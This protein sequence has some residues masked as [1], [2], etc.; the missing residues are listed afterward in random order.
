MLLRHRSQKAELLKKVPMFSNLS[1]RHLNEIAK[2]ADQLS[3]KAGKVLAE[4][5]DLGWEFVFILEGKARV[6]KNGK[7]INRLSS[8]DFFGE[9]SLIDRGPRTATVVTETDMTLLIVNSKSF[10]HLLDTVTG[11]QKKILISLCQYLRRAEKATN[12]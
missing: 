2:Y 12:I 4:Q 9:I 11:L 10:D 7:V 6:E 1:N 5:G 8:G 3:V